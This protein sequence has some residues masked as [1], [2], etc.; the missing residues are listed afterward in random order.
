MALE[1][2]TGASITEGAIDNIGM[3]SD[4]ANVCHTGEDVPRAV[5]KHILQTGNGLGGG[6]K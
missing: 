4:P 1:E 3:S 5:V 2:D 6:N